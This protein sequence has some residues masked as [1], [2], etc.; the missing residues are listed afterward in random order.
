MFFRGQRVHLA[1]SFAAPL[2]TRDLGAELLHL[3]VGEHAFAFSQHVGANTRSYFLALPLEP[4]GFNSDRGQAL[5]RLARGPSQL[6]LP[7]PKGTPLLAQLSRTASAGVDPGL[8]RRFEASRGLGRASQEP[9][10]ALGCLGQS[11]QEKGSRRLFRTF[12]W[13]AGEPDLAGRVNE[14]GVHAFV[15]GLS[16]PRESA[17][18]IAR[19]HHPPPRRRQRALV[20]G[21][22]HDREARRCGVGPQPAAHLFGLLPP[23]LDPL[24]GAPQPVKGSRGLLVTAGGLGQLFLG[25]APLVEDAAKLVVAGLA[26]ELGLGAALGHFSQAALDPLQLRRRD[27][28]TARLDLSNQLFRTLSRRR[29]QSK[30]PQALPNFILEVARTLNLDLDAGELELGP[31][32]PLLEAPQARGLLDQSPSLGRLG[33]QNLL[34]ATLPDHRMELRAQADLRE[35]LDHVGAADSCAVD[36]VFALAAAM[37]PARDRELGELDRALTV[38][39][40]E[41]E[42]DLRVVGCGAARPTREED[43]VRLL[44]AKLARAQASRGPDDRVGDIRLARAVR[45][46]DHGHARLE[47]DLDGVRERLE[48]ADLDGP[49]KQTGDQALRRGSVGEP[50]VTPR[51]RRIERRC[52]GPKSADRG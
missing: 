18:E 24:H 27:A 3:L 4:R 37:K 15:V 51:L 33:A 31:V 2:E 30:G 52:T 44:G 17:G 19:R 5:G 28:A 45:A 14:D 11:I 25:A 8:Q 47:P 7:C 32:S 16:E 6:C 41:E 12:H 39:V 34:H 10:S 38:L 42:L 29:L 22:A 23:E 46:D 48:A 40:V 26:F 50:W 21:L 13:S 36:Q 1:E 49:Q 35:Q 20:R 9:G 43:V